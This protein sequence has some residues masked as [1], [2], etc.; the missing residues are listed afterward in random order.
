M[1]KVYN[2]EKMREEM[3]EYADR[4]WYCVFNVDRGYIVWFKYPW[5]RNNF[6]Y[7]GTI[8]TPD[9]DTYPAGGLG[10]SDAKIL[11]KNLTLKEAVDYI[12][13]LFN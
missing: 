3:G 4:K 9:G 12:N 2:Y 5:C 13:Q 6:R 11:S 8:I 1:R 10:M 7:N